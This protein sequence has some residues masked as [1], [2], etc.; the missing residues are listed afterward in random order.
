[1]ASSAGEDK[2]RTPVWQGTFELDYHLALLL[3]KGML[4]VVISST[5]A[6]SESRTYQLQWSPEPVGA[7]PFITPL[8]YT[9]P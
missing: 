1:M 5:E 8:P 4:E 3:P 6:V 9:R 2:S 7:E